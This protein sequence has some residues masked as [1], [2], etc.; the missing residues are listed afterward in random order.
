MFEI[1][2]R[3]IKVGDIVRL[4]L[5]TGKEPKG[6]VLEIG[7]NFVLLETE[8]KTRSI[9][10]DRLIGGWEILKTIE[11]IEVVSIPSTNDGS[12]ILKNSDE[13]MTDDNQIPKRITDYKVGET[14]PLELLKKVT[15]NKSKI[16]K[17]KSKPTATFKSFASLEQLISED[18]K[19]ENK[20]IVS[21]NGVIT[22]CYSERS[23]GFIT[24]RFGYDVWFGFQNILDEELLT[25]LK[26]TSLKCNIPVIFTLSKNNKG[27]FASYIHKPNTI[28][29]ILTKIS[30]FSKENKIEMAFGLIEQILFSYPSNR[31]A[32][33]YKEKLSAEIKNKNKTLGKT[34]IFDFN[35]Q[36]AVKAKTIEKD[37]NAALKFYM[38]AFENNEKRES[39]IKDIGMLYVQ[40]QEPEKALE[41]INKYKNELQKTV[42][43][44]N[45]LNSFYSSVRVFDKVIK[46]IDLL[47]EE[48]TTLKDR[49]KHSFYLSQ[50]G[51]ALIQ[52]KKIEKARVILDEAIGIS[53]ENTYAI[54]LL[55]ALDEPDIDKQSQ[56]IAEAEF[57]SFGGGL[58]KFIKNTLDNYEEYSGIPA[59]VIDTGN[60]TYV[61]LKALRD[62]IDT[63]GRARPRERANYLL[64]EAKL[65]VNLEPEKETGLRSVLARYCNAMAL[66]HVSE[67]SYMDVIRNYYLEAFGLEEK[68]QFTAPQVALFLI[69]YKSTYSELLGS[70]TP[71][72]DEALKLVIDSETKD[73]IWEGILSMFLWNRSISAILIGKL[74]AN[75][76][77]KDNSMPFLKKIGVRIEKNDISLDDYIILWNIARDIRQRD[78]RRWLAS[79]KAIYSND[80]LEI[81]FNQLK[82][83]TSEIKKNWLTSLDTKR[84]TIIIT[85]IVDILNQY[86]K[87]NRYIDKE[88]L[89]GNAKT[90]V[91]QLIGEIKEL[92][93][94]LSYEGFLPLLEKIILLLDNSF[95]T[96][97]SAS[98]PVVKIS[99][100][101]EASIVTDK[102]VPIKIQVENSK[103][104][105]P[106]RDISICIKES[107]EVKSKDKAEYYDSVN[108]GEYCELH[109]KAELSEKV[110]QNK[111][112]TVTVICNYKRRNQDEPISINEQLSLRLYSEEE[113][114]I[115]P[116]PYE[117][118]ANGG[119]VTDTKMFYG[120]NEFID[121]ITE[122]IIQTESKQ[123]VIYGQKRSGKS[124]VLHHLKKSLEKTNRTFC[125][126]FSIGSIFENISTETFFY[127]IID[128]I[129]EELEN[130]D[131]VTP[132]FKCPTFSDFKNVPSVSDFF[133]KQIRLFKK[134]C[135][136]LNEWKDKK[137]VIMIDE[138]T[139]LYSGIC[140]G[141]ITQDFMKQW[142]AITQNEDS[143]FSSVLVG[144]DVFPMFKD[145]FPNEFGVTQDER[146]TYLSKIDAVRLIEEPMGKTKSGRNRFIGNALDTI[147][148][149][150]S[151]NP[152]YIQIFCARLVSEM[153]RKKHIEVTSADVKEIA[154]SF[155]NG[156]QALTDDKFDNLLNAG[157]EHDIQKYKQEI[158]KAILKSIATNAKN[159]HFCL[160]EQISI[161]S[162]EVDIDEVLK[163]LVKR[164]VLEQIENRYKI[165]VKLFQEWLLKH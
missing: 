104:S 144:Q 103:N 90:Q 134:K 165:Q 152:Y 50:K 150:T 130:Y 19:E 72:V 107:D 17:V 44:Y 15:G 39:C 58:S 141:K 137:L 109:L 40:M 132:D 11:K 101:G 1:F 80:N 98:I 33:N 55:Q 23:F 59:K 36:K 157:E 16:P 22:G 12:Q 32:I 10:F 120:R 156:G 54:R 87:Q 135:S 66:N 95:K 99:I 100:L 45:Y 5:T 110:I 30:S 89:H 43:T 105:S 129:A 64:T 76:T 31:S 123:V 18:I 60:F 78:Y 138:F 163:D 82:D 113:F 142:K 143:M 111:A 48:R 71:S 119:P 124:S 102:T 27:D 26:Q 115:I 92:P 106:I 148:D 86:L 56:I 158:S 42:V 62:L 49:R 112:T 68:Y 81:I 77:F 93:T 164:E 126:S 128:L 69:S 47:V 74:Y 53:P 146:L 3:D 6:T 37:L 28:E 75:M 46:Y 155:I 97:E 38:L 79:L 153:N 35:Y 96:I 88:R 117:I 94:K 131:G 159:I 8:D 161:E 154:E 20:Q 114:E 122:A 4:S 121:R 84:L 2:K 116:N 85:D 65:M 83:S 160:R 145:K 67:N 51:Y 25:Q 136:M 52:T 34:R 147:I 7:D 162:K 24:D 57:D 70:K 21:A 29:Q 133:R 61:T 125:V 149:Y 118:L 139:Y 127:K 14:V 91:F 63:A 151:C 73:S 140:N 108:G 41:F 9:F 13:P